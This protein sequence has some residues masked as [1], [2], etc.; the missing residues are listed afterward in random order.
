MARTFDLKKVLA[1]VGDIVRKLKKRRDHLMSEVELIEGE[2]TRLGGGRKG[3][4]KITEEAIPQRRTGKRK[5]RSREE[6]TAMAQQIVDFIKGKG[7]EGAAAKDLQR[8]FGPLLPSVNAWLKLYSPG[9]VKT[10]GV[11]SKMR[12]FA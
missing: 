4:R 2:L 5:R 8:Q 7:K 11:K 6:L 3:R 9:K 10:S 1:P 12:Y